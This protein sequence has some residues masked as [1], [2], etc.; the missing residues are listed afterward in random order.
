MLRY[1]SAGFLVQIAKFYF[2][3]SSLFLVIASHIRFN[4]NKY[5]NIWISYVIL[6]VLKQH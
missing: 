4:L 5:S 2:A 1:N 3:I 6:G